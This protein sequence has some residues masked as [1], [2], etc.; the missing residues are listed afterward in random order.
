[1]EDDTLVPVEGTS[2]GVATRVRQRMLAPGQLKEKRELYSSRQG[3]NRELWDMAFPLDGT[4][5]N[6]HAAAM[7]RT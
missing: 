6:L 4:V 3:L 2:E 5:Q 1:M 7:R